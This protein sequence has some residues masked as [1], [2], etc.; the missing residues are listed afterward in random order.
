MITSLLPRVNN[1]FEPPSPESRENPLESGVP[2]PGSSPAELHSSSGPPMNPSVEVPDGEPTS[3]KPASSE[4]NRGTIGKWFRT[5]M[6]KWSHNRTSR[7]TPAEAPPQ[8]GI[9]SETKAPTPKEKPSTMAP[10]KR[11]AVSVPTC[12]DTAN[13]YL[14][15]RLSGRFTVVCPRLVH[16]SYLF[17]NTIAYCASQKKKPPKT[18]PRSK[19]GPTNVPAQTTGAQ[20]HTEVR[21][22]FLHL[23]AGTYKNS[24][25]QANRPG[26]LVQKLV[27]PTSRMKRNPSLLLRKT[28]QR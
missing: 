19:A 9:P 21:V 22:H 13:G 7:Q 16:A 3:D 4:G 25:S 28:T 15:T 11:Q 23:A 12:V 1:A 27:P 20:N 24:S 14:T 26:P 6:T 5:V 10:G 8:S 17:M 2:A 18:T